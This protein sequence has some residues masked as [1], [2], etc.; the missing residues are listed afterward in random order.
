[1]NL[2]KYPINAGTFLGILSTAW[3]AQAQVTI[4]SEDMFNQIGQYYLAY[5]SKGDVVIGSKVLGTTGGSQLWDFTTGPKDDTYRFDYVAP[6]DG[7]HGADFPKAKVA[8]RKKEQIKGSTAWL[9]FEQVPG[10]GRQTYGFYDP[11]F[12]ADQPSTPFKTPIVDFP[13]TIH[14][15]DTWSTS[16]SFRSDIS[17]G[18]PPDPDDPDD[19]GGSFS[20]PVLFNYTST[21]VA[22]AFGLINLPG[23]GFG[24][25]LRVNELVTYDIQ[26]DLFGDGEFQTVATEYIR[27]YYWLMEDH[28]IAVQITSKQQDSIPSNDFTT[29]AS[30][31]RMF[32]TNHQIGTSAPPAPDGITG[33]K[34]TYGKASVLIKWDTTSA[35]KTYKVEYTTNLGSKNSWIPLG[36][37][38]TNNFMLDTS[39]PSA[40]SRFYRVIGTN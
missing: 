39:V 16:T 2:L 20:I 32:E 6:T 5:A 4:T 14:Y 19:T 17:F 22:D 24:G 13:D 28:G 11:E 3:L 29:A 10:L 25:C 7:G 8:E 1:M 21:A 23:V 31:V 30:F 37:S 15:R 38:T 9:Y 33:L 40:S 34:L 26:A 27:N 18:A 12:S 36:V 35:V